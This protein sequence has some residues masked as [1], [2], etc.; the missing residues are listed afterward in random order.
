ML[1]DARAGGCGDGSPVENTTYYDLT[2]FAECVLPFGRFAS[3]SEGWLAVP[4][5]AADTVLEEHHVK[6]LEELVVLDSI[7]DDPSPWRS[8]LPSCRTSPMR[9]DGQP[10][11]KAS[12]GFKLVSMA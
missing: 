10:T 2:A 1:S 5:E 7:L 6:I 4:K 12:L 3:L 9:T 11:P 8:T